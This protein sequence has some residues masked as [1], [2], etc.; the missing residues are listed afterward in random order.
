MTI[1]PFTIKQKWKLLKNHLK[2]SLFCILIINLSFWSNTNDFDQ[3]KLNLGY[4]HEA[5]FTFFETSIA[6]VSYHDYVIS[7]YLYKFGTSLKLSEQEI[8]NKLLGQKI[9]PTKQ[10]TKN[11]ENLNLYLYQQPNSRDLLLHK[12]NLNFQLKNMS[13]FTE[14]IT[15]LMGLD[16]NHPKVKQFQ[17][18]QSKII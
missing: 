8:N 12:A 16:P 14:T 1:I 11:L 4:T 5:K 3:L 9:Y 2:L 7:K 18:L 17:K 13:E 15:L 10:L 6:A